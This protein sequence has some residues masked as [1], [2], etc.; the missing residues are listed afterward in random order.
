MAPSRCLRN[1]IGYQ[2]PVET[3]QETVVENP[4][5]SMYP[6]SARASE[7]RCPNPTTAKTCPVVE[8]MILFKR[9]IM[10]SSRVSMSILLKTGYLFR[11]A[12]IS[13][14]ISSVT[15]DQF[16]LL[17]GRTTRLASASTTSFAFSFLG[18]FLNAAPVLWIGRS[19]NSTLDP[20]A[21]AAF[22]ASNISVPGADP[23]NWPANFSNNAIVRN[24]TPAPRPL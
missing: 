7:A 11:K 18:S 20:T 16:I 4:G 15:F 3:F 6:V 9:L 22:A 21:F 14:S 19:M 12:P 24:D 10:Y 13:E 2:L 17:N 8:S 5:P 1:W 23:V